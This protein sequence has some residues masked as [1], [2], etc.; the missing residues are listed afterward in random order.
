MSQYFSAKLHKWLYFEKTIPADSSLVD[1]QTCWSVAISR[2]SLQV[3][4]ILL[5]SHSDAQN[6][7]KSS[8]PGSDAQV[9]S[10]AANVMG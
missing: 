2:D 9:F 7:N 4:W 6:R 5:P 10:L 1:P 8:S 3:T